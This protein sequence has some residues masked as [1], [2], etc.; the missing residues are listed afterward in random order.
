MRVKSDK[1]G[2]V[3]VRFVYTD[4]DKRTNLSDNM[5][6]GLSKVSDEKSMGGLL[7]SLGDNRRAMGLLSTILENGK[8]VENGYYEMSDTLMLVRKEDTKTAGFIRE[9]FSIPHQLVSMDECSVLI[10]DVI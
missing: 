8:V 10:I 3:T 7:Y 6:W 2:N 1:G 9:K 5:F 4:T